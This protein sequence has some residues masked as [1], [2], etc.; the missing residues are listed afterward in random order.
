VTIRTGKDSFGKGGRR[1]CEFR[2][3][4]FAESIIRGKKEEG[5]KC[6][7]KNDDLFFTFHI[8]FLQGW[9]MLKAKTN[10]ANGTV[11]N[12]HINIVTEKK[13]KKL[14]NLWGYIVI[15]V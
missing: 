12:N 11:K 4:I 3:I 2:K 9:K 8:G 5:K 14:Y 7:V 6:Q 15:E 13:G 1:N 10:K